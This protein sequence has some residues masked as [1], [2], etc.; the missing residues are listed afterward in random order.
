MSQATPLSVS[1]LAVLMFLAHEPSWALDQ[2]PVTAGD[3]TA[4]VLE[5]HYGPD[6]KARPAEFTWTFNPDGTFLVKRDKG[7]IA[8]HLLRT[9]LDL[10]PDRDVPDVPQV[11]GRWALKGG[12]IRLTDARA[13][14]AA[15]TA[16]VDL[17]VY[18]TA[19]TIIRIDDW[20]AAGDHSVQIQ[21]V[22]HAPVD[23]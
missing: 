12:R 6:R 7:A 19:P 21:Y 22:F 18:R 10:K 23:K 13:G 14:D 1:T 9:L 8:P 5:Q 16:K 11:S 15:G 3:V 17:H 20:Q 2:A 4:M